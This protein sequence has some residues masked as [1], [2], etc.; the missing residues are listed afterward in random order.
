MSK[1]AEASIRAHEYGAKKIH[2]QLQ[3]NSTLLSTSF[4]KLT[5][6]IENWELYLTEKQREVANEFIKCLSTTE[7]DRRLKLTEGSTYHRLFGSTGKS[8]GAFG[9]LKQVQKMLQEHN[10]K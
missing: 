3:K 1:Y 8:L 4:R 10:E 9:R 2:T 5:E 6:E 7:V